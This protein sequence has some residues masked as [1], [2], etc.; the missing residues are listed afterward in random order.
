MAAAQD[1]SS[2]VLLLFADQFR[3]DALGRA[4]NPV[5]RTPNLDRLGCRSHA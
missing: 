1:R 5:V 3:I 2:N 4:G